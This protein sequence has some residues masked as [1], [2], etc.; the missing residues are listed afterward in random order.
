M[1]YPAELIVANNNISTIVTPINSTIIVC[2]YLGLLKNIKNIIS[3]I[4]KKTIDWQQRLEQINE[5][6]KNNNINHYVIFY[7]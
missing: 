1:N 4:P 2:H 7:E 5:I 6:T 3:Y